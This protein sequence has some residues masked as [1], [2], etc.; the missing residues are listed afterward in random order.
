MKKSSVLVAALGIVIGVLLC[1]LGLKIKQRNA[2]RNWTYGDWRKLSLI[3]DHVEKNYVD[4]INVKGMTDAAIEAALA[5]LDPHSI[6]LPPVELKESETELKGNFDGI[7]IQFNVPNDTAIV[8]N[9]ISGGPSEKAGLMT[10]DRIIAVDERNIAG[11]RTPQDSMVA[12]MK[13][14][15]GSKVDIHVLRGEE[16]ITFNI[17]RGKIPVNCVDA[18][19]MVNDT[20]GYL[21]LSKFSRT[22]MLQSTRGG[23]PFCPPL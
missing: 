18:S 7:G 22:T 10:G 5:K 8:L 6:Y 14:R 19:F 4:T 12:L 23:H 21:K 17:T 9:V 1:L 2:M 16:E 15:S 11:V 13:G 3:L 20:T